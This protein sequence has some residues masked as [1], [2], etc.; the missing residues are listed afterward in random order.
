LYAILKVKHYFF[1]RTKYNK[2]RVE[3]ATESLTNQWEAVKY[4]LPVK[5][6]AMMGIAVRLPD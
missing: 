5:G 1:D 6:D 2:K 4:D 3:K